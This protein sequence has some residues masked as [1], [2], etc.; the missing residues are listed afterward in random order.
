M[1]AVGGMLVFVAVAVSFFAG[2]VEVVG[3]P[4]RGGDG[5]GGVGRGR[6]RAARLVLVVVGSGRPFPWVGLV[7]LVAEV[8]TFVEAAGYA[9]GGSPSAW[10][11]A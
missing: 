9:E 7:S 3:G 8:V 6:E 1:T 4:R 2:S 10:W 11:G 5:R